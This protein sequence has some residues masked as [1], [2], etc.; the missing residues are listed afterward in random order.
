MAAVDKA[1]EIAQAIREEEAL[2]AATTANPQLE[3]VILSACLRDRAALDTAK[4]AI[5]EDDFSTRSSRLMWTAIT[6]LDERGTD[7]NPVTLI[8]ELD[9]TEALK[10]IG[11]ADAVRELFTENSPTSDILSYCE[12]LR[13]FSL[14]REQRR[15][16]ISLQGLSRK[17]MSGAER[18]SETRKLLDRVESKSLLRDSLETVDN[19]VDRVG[20]EAII[21]P[22]RGE[23]ELPWEKANNIL[24]GLRRG[25]LNLLGARPSQ[26]KTS[27]AMEIALHNVRTKG[28]R[29][30]VFSLETTSQSMY[31]RAACRIAMISGYKALTGTLTPA[32]AAALRDALASLMGSDLLYI[33]NLYGRTTTE[34][35]LGIRRLKN[36]GKPPELVIIDHVHKMR[37][38]HKVKDIREANVEISNR[39]SEMPKEDGIPF[40][41]LGQLARP[42]GKAMLE[43][44]TVDSFKESGSWEA[45]T[46][47]AMIINRPEFYKNEGDRSKVILYIDKNRD[48]PTGRCELKAEDKYF[49]YEEVDSTYEE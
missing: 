5:K 3:K 13:N 17:P 39:L 47:T 2:A 42:F 26:G 36:E 32:E 29:V 46:D 44:P 6:S 45:D 9:A 12:Q 49:C 1:L 37:P 33:S 4:S 35:Q 15:I 27:M 31:L 34:I 16:G 24:M 48:G 7:A 22:G 43:R 18:I 11:G 30:A 21:N 28:K 8:A 40:L 23:I 38:V 41:A 14:A 25:T 20:L 10:T 19:V